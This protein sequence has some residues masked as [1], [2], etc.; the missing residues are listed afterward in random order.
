MWRQTHW[1]SISRERG[2]GIRCLELVRFHDVGCIRRITDGLYWWFDS[3]FAQEGENIRNEYRKYFGEIFEI[4]V[5]QVLSAIYGEKNIQ[6]E[7]QYGLRGERRFIDWW[8]LNGDK[9]YLFEAKANQ[10]NLF[11]RS[12]CDPEKYKQEEIPKIA[13][14]IKQLFLRVK[15]IQD[16]SYPE[17]HQFQGKNIIPVAIFL[18]MPFVAEMGLYRS[19]ISEELVRMEDLDRN[20]LGISQFNVYLINI[21]E[22]E[23]YQSI[24][25]EVP[26]EEVFVRNN[27]L[28]GKSNIS[29]AMRSFGELRSQ[30]L[31]D[32]YNRFFMPMQTSGNELIDED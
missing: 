16:G 8:M 30:F 28:G 29:S 11:N 13:K 23:P 20:L 14:A 27:Q 31:D 6:K 21:S 4:Y 17:L 1:S 3:Q 12:V 24:V 25:G 22:L 19:W 5:G 2:S 9:L 32:A 10:V 7:F 18:D 26:L 15:D